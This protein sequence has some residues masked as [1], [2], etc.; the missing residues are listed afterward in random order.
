MRANLQAYVP[1]CVGCVGVCLR[2][3]VS[4]CVCV[5]ARASVHAGLRAGARWQ[6]SMRIYHDDGHEFK[7]VC[8]GH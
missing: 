2:A 5:R 8:R 3:Y 1:G 6:L 7:V 4:M